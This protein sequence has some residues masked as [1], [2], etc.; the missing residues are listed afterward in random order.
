M[1]WQ[2]LPLSVSGQWLVHIVSKYSGPLPPAGGQWW[3]PLT[4]ALW[5]EEC[6]YASPFWRGGAPMH[7]RTFLFQEGGGESNGIFQRSWTD[8]LSCVRKATSLRNTERAFPYCITEL[9]YQPLE[10]VRK[11]N[12]HLIELLLIRFQNGSH[13]EWIHIFCRTVVH[14]HRS[15]WKAALGSQ[16]NWG[17]YTESPCFHTH[18]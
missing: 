8:L 17:K 9:P 4:P 10:L 2:G 5:S 7:S 11:M 12:V 3:A 16:Q 13:S 6:N 1:R 18:C 14:S 15:L